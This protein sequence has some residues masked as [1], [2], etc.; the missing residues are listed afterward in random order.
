MSA[1]NMQMSGHL[2]GLKSENTRHLILAPGSDNRYDS[3]KSDV[4]NTI[5]FILDFI[6]HSVNND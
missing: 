3:L 5:G 2:N 4:K 1:K 6:I